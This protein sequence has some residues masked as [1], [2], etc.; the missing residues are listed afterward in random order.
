MSIS[1]LGWRAQF[2]GFVGVGGQEVILEEIGPIA[3]AISAAHVI[4]LYTLCV[5][6]YC[7]GAVDGNASGHKFFFD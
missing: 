2:V 4:S 6:V 3:H 5:V 7:C 1:R